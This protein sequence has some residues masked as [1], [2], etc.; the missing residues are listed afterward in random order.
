LKSAVTLDEEEISDVSLGTFYVSDKEATGTSQSGQG[1]QLAAGCRDRGRA[2]CVGRLRR[3]R[4]SL[5]PV[6]GSLPKLLDS[7]VFPFLYGL[8]GRI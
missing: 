2:G 1:V 4:L 3:L 6:V 7:G 8:Q 5:L